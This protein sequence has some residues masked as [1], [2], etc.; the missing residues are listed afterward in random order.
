M[1][2]SMMTQFFGDTL[3]LKRPSFICSF[4]FTKRRVWL[5]I[6]FIITCSL[7]LLS[8]FL[9]LSLTLSFSL[10]LS[11]SFFLSLSFS[12]SLSLTLSFFLSL[13]FSIFLSLSFSLS[14]S[15]SFSLS[16]SLSLKVSY[17]MQIHGFFR[18]EFLRKPLFLDVRDVLNVL[19]QSN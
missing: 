3:C 9:S 17:L 7:S 4:H 14:L 5:S 15:L 2:R 6:L 11:F 10:S 16:I 13:S 19:L 8:L 18:S 1:S 12:F